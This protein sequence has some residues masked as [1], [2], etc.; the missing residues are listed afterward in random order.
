MV[1]GERSGNGALFSAKVGTI[2]R[3]ARKSGNGM[4]NSAEGRQ[5]EIGV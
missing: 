4:P 1:R 3:W 2:S 5:G